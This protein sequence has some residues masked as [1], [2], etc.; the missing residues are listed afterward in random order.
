MRTLAIGSALAAL[1]TIGVPA[2]SSSSGSPEGPTNHNDTIATS[3]DDT[4][5]DAT[6]S[7]SEAGTADAAEPHRDGA[8]APLEAS[9]DD[10][11]GYATYDADGVE[12]GTEAGRTTEG[13]PYAG[14]GD[15]CSEALPCPPCGATTPQCI[16]GYCSFLCK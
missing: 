14:E 11:A 3:P 2:C 10:G 7:G 1:G 5:P 13:G 16:G 12:A 6:S 8:Q 15:A 9:I 4:S